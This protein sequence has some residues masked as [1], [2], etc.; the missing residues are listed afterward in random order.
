MSDVR[1]DERPADPIDAGAAPE[2]DVR[3][4]VERLGI[5]SYGRHLFL[6]THGD[7]ASDEQARTSWKYLK[8]RLR[9]LGLERA[10]GGVYRTRASCF[11]ICRDG[12][13]ALVYPDGIWYRACT[14]ENLE[15]ILQ[16]HLIGGRPVE[17]LVIAR[18]PL[19]A[20]PGSAGAP[21]GGSA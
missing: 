5:G 20:P 1:D 18:N 9:E 21:A 6:C 3:R 13:I 10:P 19:P 14:P 7:C 8:R 16:E 12:P 15:R 2:P 17:A 4:V 11:R